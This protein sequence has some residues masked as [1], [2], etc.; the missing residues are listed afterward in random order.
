MIGAMKPYCQV[1]SRSVPRVLE[2]AAGE[3]DAPLRLSPDRPRSGPMSGYLRPGLPLLRD[4]LQVEV[5]HASVDRALRP[6]QAFSF[7]APFAFSF[8]LWT[9][10]GFTVSQ[11][12]PPNDVLA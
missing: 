6:L 2:D 5:C 1:S 12:L 7:S 4:E 9:S 11:G 3:A 8:P 10:S